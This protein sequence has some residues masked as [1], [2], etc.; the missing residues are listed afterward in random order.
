MAAVLIPGVLEVCGKELTS[1]VHT[2]LGY[3]FFTTKIFVENYH[4]QSNALILFH[5]MHPRRHFRK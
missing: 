1:I 4:I 3:Y 2:S 5:D